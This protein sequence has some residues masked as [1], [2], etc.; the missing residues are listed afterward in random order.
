MKK[1][2]FLIALLLS[3]ML[4]YGYESINIY[5]EYINQ[6][7]SKVSL[8]YALKSK[9][10]IYNFAMNLKSN[11]ILFERNSTYVPYIEENS[12]YYI[13]ITG[14]IINDSMDE[15][16]IIV[17]IKYTLRDI[18]MS[19]IKIYK[20]YRVNESEM[21]FSHKKQ[22]E[23]LHNATNDT[24]NISVLEN[25][26]EKIIGDNMSDDIEENRSDEVNY[27]E[28]KID[29]MEEE[30]ATLPAINGS[31]IIDKDNITDNKEIIQNKDSTNYMLYIILGL[32][33]GIVIALLLI[34]IYTM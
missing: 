24:I 17:D 31:T 13:N 9:F 23:I 29:I 25:R 18:P 10:P 33:S 4:C 16:P 21:A 20:I 1:I 30:E 2:I 14:R 19:Y 6:S 26:T 8:N 3:P 15:Y 7:T 27:T 22:V 5:P 12:I 28:E 32:V 11:G 34:Y